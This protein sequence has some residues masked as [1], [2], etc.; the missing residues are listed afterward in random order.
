MR[1]SAGSSPPA[2]ERVAQGRRRRRAL[3]GALGAASIATGVFAITGELGRDL[4]DRTGAAST[5]G[6]LRAVG[7]AP[8]HW[9]RALVSDVPVD[10]LSLDIR[11]KHLHRL[12]EKRDD[13]LRSGILV[14]R[15]ADVVPVGLRSNGEEVSAR[16]RLA[17]NDPELLRGEKWPLHVRTRGNGHVK[18]M[19][20]FTLWAPEARGHGA[21]QGFL[22]HVRREDVLAPRSLIVDVTRNGKHLGLMALV[23]SPS[24]E[25]L[26]SQQRRDGPMLRFD[27]A[28][29]ARG[30]PTDVSVISPLRPAAVARSR[31]LERAFE[32]ADGLLRGFLAGDL[33]AGAVFDAERMGRYRALAEL[34]G[35]PSPFGWRTLRLYYNPL[36]ARLEPIAQAAGPGLRPV[37]DPHDEIAQP[38]AD[39]LALDPDLRSAYSAAMARIAAAMSTETFATDLAERDG[40]LLLLLHREYPLRAPFDPRAI[41]RRAGTLA[42][43]V[44]TSGGVPAAPRVADR[45]DGGTALALP[46]PGVEA[47]LAQHAFL[48]FDAAAREL[49]AAAGRWDVDGSLILPEH[50]GL[51]LPAGTVLRFQSRQGLIARGPLTFLGTEARPVVLEG[52]PGRK[53]S[54]LWSGVYVVESPRPS[55]WS[56][57]VVRN[58]AGFKRNGWSLSGGVV[59]RKARIDME[60][61]TL[62][63]NRSDD[64]LNIVRSEFSLTNVTIVESESDGFDGDYVNGSINGGLIARAGGDAIDVG[65]SRVDVRG[66]RLVDIRDKAI[67]V[68]ERSHLSAQAV[69]IENASIGVASK[70]GSETRI[71]DSTIEGISDVALVAYA[72][73]PEYGPGL[74]IASDNRITRANLAALSQSGSRLVLDGNVQPDFDIAIDRLYRDREKDR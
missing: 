53:R 20:R 23:E 43:R 52:P 9:L 22:D 62:S 28:P 7:L 16:L 5:P 18:G 70:N 50:V 55:R 33:P 51:R 27:A 38:L 15:D 68:G 24:T 1:V 26:A 54:E 25:M 60:D 41:L 67:S 4:R 58:T 36:T 29:R 65:G 61:C 34:W 63:G 49:R 37:D 2:R 35:V 30:R 69:A 31:R 21:E 59:F 11:F 48:S 14:P 3:F 40:A 17:G 74:L 64:S 45:L 57:V 39:R 66:T 13:A 32:T 12:H 46:R 44:R 73:R 47:V 19:R 8:L 71:T 42:N 10:R 6:A 56:H 72:N